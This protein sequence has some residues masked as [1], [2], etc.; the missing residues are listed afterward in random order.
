[1][2]RPAPDVNGVLH[3]SRCSFPDCNAG[4]R[5][6]VQC[7]N[8]NKAPLFHCKSTFSLIGRTEWIRHVRGRRIWNT[9]AME[10]NVQC[11]NSIITHQHKAAGTEWGG[12]KQLNH[13][14]KES[15]YPHLNHN[16]ALCLRRK[17]D[18]N[19]IDNSQQYRSPDKAN[20]LRQA[21]K[22]K[23]VTEMALS[24]WGHHFPPVLEKAGVG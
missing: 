22:E 19:F 5:G 12:R 10:I 24:N 9:E 7:C 13:P 15:S 21:P 8:E 23:Q 4:L 11:V 14:D 1:M 20:P 6:V 3:R 17:F 16:D 2:T 18:A